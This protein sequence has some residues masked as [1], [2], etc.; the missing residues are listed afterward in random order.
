MT[1]IPA[2]HPPLPRE[3]TWDRHL[4]ATAAFEW[5]RAGW[6][7]LWIKPLASLGY[8]LLVYLISVA[9]IVGL[10]ALGLDYILF[11]AIA[12]FMVV[13]P[14]L[15]LGLY[16]KSRQLAAGTDQRR[17]DD[18]GEIEVRRTGAVCRHSALL[19]DAGLD[20]GG[21]HHLRLVFRTSPVPRP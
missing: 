19:A 1:T 12:G 7:D 13:G 18:P 16:E 3:R 17:A 5:L 6:H 15:A 4:P 21:G 20:A 2:V 11:P 14:V 8:G 10:F 9:I